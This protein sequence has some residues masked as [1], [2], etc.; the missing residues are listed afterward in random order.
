MRKLS[1]V[2][3]MSFHIITEGKPQNNDEK[4]IKKCVLHYKMS[5]VSR[6]GFF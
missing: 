5:N 2:P 6:T 1:Y 3:I 4:I